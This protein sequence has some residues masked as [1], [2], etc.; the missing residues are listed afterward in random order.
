MYLNTPHNQREYWISA[1][2]Y[3]GLDIVVRP[4]HNYKVMNLYS[5]M[6]TN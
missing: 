5:I 1:Y 3:K 4:F 6:M 2:P